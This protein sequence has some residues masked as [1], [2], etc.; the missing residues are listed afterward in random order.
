[1]KLFFY[2]DKDKCIGCGA[3][4]LISPEL[5]SFDKNGKAR[6]NVKY[7]EDEQKIFLVKKAQEACPVNAIIVEE[8]D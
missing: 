7:I 4:I 8:L 3:C 5:F 6:E 2:V 1:M